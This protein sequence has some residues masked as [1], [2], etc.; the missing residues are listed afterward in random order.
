MQRPTRR[1]RVGHSPVWTASYAL[2]R[3]IRSRPAACSTVSRRSLALEGASTLPLDVFNTQEAEALL[4]GIAGAKRIGTES[5]AVRDLIRL[6]GR[7][8]LALALVARRLQA[9]PAWTV[10]DLVIRLSDAGGRLNGFLLEYLSH[11]GEKYWGVSSI[12]GSRGD[13]SSSFATG[14]T[15]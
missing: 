9:R 8:P 11:G 12:A 4:I 13:E 5:E 10:H 7:L 6:C 15:V 2:L 3:S 1:T 14:R